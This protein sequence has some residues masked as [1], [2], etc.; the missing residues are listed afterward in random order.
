MDEALFLLC[1]VVAQGNHEASSKISEA[2]IKQNHIDEALDQ[3]QQRLMNESTR[4]NLGHFASVAKVAI[5][6]RV[7]LKW[8]FP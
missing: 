4:R 5:E 2:Y 6:R 1:V 7:T 3:Y 8:T